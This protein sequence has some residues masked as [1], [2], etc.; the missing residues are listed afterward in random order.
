MTD[1]KWKQEILIKVATK[2][3][4]HWKTKHVIEALN[5]AEE[6]FRDIQSTSIDHWEKLELARR[7]ISSLEAE[8]KAMLERIEKILNKN[9]KE[10][11]DLYGKQRIFNLIE[12]ELKKPTGKE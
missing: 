2:D 9:N 3:K 10:F 12:E 11:R 5:L 8:K 1:E 6:H 4:E 7:E